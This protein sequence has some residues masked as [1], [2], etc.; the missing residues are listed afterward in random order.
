MSTYLMR[1]AACVPDR[2]K[3]KLCL[4]GVYNFT[5]W[6][7][8]YTYQI[9]SYWLAAPTNYAVESGG[10]A[11]YD[12]RLI[13]G[14]DNFEHPLKDPFE[15]V[16]NF[17]VRVP[18]GNWYAGEKTKGY[19]ID[20]STGV[21]I[22]GTDCFPVYPIGSNLFESLT[23]YVARHSI[24]GGFSKDVAGKTNKLHASAAN[25]GDLGAYVGQ[26]IA[27]FYKWDTCELDTRTID[28]NTYPA[29]VF[30]EYASAY[31]HTDGISVSFGAS[32]PSYGRRLDTVDTDGYIKCS[33]LTSIQG[34]PLAFPLGT[35][36]PAFKTRAGQ[37]V[38]PNSY[39][40]V[41]SGFA[42]RPKDPTLS[43]K[44]FT[45]PYSSV[46]SITLDTFTTDYGISLRRGFQFGIRKFKKKPYMC[47]VGHINTSGSCT[48][49]D[50]V[51]E[52]SH[53][54][55][56]RWMLS[57]VYNLNLVI[58]LKVIGNTYKVLWM[59]GEI[60]THLPVIGFKRTADLLW[61]ESSNRCGLT[62][63][64]VAASAQAAI[65][66]QIASYFSTGYQWMSGPATRQSTLSKGE[67]TINFNSTF[68]LDLNY[69]GTKQIHTTITF[70]ATGKMT[71][72][73]VTIDALDD[74]T[75][76]ATRYGAWYVNSNSSG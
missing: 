51:A 64:V 20:Y 8:P 27:Y 3:G 35:Y 42:Y 54:T 73:S 36:S 29:V 70:S 2:D 49:P 52:L 31:D 6:T 72:F 1:Y 38:D 61:N 56:K 7:N 40:G 32:Q 17:A 15:N 66:A 11:D 46:P 48:V 10:V 4:S 22:T 65:D 69:A 16:S 62:Q 76:E 21:K 26:R 57:D 25:I 14:I 47:K 71:T 9:P 37:S 28:S 67:S 43:V 44:N 68:Q 18:A 50:A 60:E 13:K 74:A 55:L 41:L 45:T 58:D 19:A 24:T 39:T 5:V 34:M 30:A 75:D 53:S 33:T 12:Y 23:T 63:L 59:L